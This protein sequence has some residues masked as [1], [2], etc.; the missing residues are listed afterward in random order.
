MLPKLETEG[1]KLNDKDADKN[2]AALALPAGKSELLEWDDDLP[3]FGVRLRD[4]GSKTWMIQYRVGRKQRRKTIGS[5]NAMDAAT[6]RKAAKKDLARVELGGDPQAHKV[7]Q[8]ASNRPIP[9]A[10]SRPSFSIARGSVSSPGASNRSTRTW[11]NIGSTLNGLSIRAIDKRD[12]CE[13]AYKD[14][15][16]KRGAMRGEPGESDAVKPVRMGDERRSLSTPT[17]SSERKT[18]PTDEP[19]RERV[20]GRRGTCQLSGALAATT[21]MAGSSRLLILT[22]RGATKSGPS[23]AEIN[24][25]PP[26]EH[27]ERAHKKQPAA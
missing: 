23:K 11:S 17:P 26:V 13:P 4:G 25:A 27:P 20:L 7:E 10:P 24:L 9:S 22:G 16:G 6:A 1:M 5:A 15:S 14:R 19:G 21:I 2:V 12:G 8:R 18:R 3:G